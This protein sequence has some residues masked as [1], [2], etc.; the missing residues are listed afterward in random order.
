[1]PAHS[2]QRYDECLFD[3]PEDW[4]MQLAPTHPHNVDGTPSYICHD[5]LLDT[6]T[7]QK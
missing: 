6:S 5:S 2:L 4:D 7:N 1:M 3:I